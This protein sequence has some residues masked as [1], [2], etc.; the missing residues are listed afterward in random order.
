[1][2]HQKP[3]KLVDD[4]RLWR[5]NDDVLTSLDERQLLRKCNQVT[6]LDQIAKV[7][8]RLRG[9]AAFLL[10]KAILHLFEGPVLHQLDAITGLV[11]FGKCIRKIQYR[12]IYKWIVEAEVSREQVWIN[13]GK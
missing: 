9:G 13:R 12:T 5:R 11:N 4:D 10:L 1:M 6:I 8:N 3:R 7:P 2:V